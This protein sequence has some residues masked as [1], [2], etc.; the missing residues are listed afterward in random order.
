MTQSQQQAGRKCDSHH[1][2][3]QE[4]KGGKLERNRQGIRI[5][6]RKR[7]KKGERKEKEER[8]KGRKK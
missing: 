3:R 8:K 4:A 7:G 5:V 1:N 2:S 6:E